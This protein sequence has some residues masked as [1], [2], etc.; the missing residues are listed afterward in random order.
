[1]TLNTSRHLVLSVGH[2]SHLTFFWQ[3][4]KSGFFDTFTISL[5]LQLHKCFDGRQEL[6]LSLSE[7]IAQQTLVL[8]K[9]ECVFYGRNLPK[10]IFKGLKLKNKIKRQ[11]NN[12]DSI[13]L[14]HDNS[15]LTTNLLASCFKN[16]L[17]FKQFNQYDLSNYKKDYFNILLVNT[18]NLFLSKFMNVVRLSSE[19]DSRVHLNNFDGP[20]IKIDS[21]SKERDV[22]NFGKSATK[23]KKNG[24]CIV[25]IPFMTWNISSDS[26]N[27]ILSTYSSVLNSKKFDGKIYY[28]RH[29]NE[30]NA[31]IAAIR[32]VTRDRI[33]D[34]T[35]EFISSEHFFLENPDLSM[36]LSVGSYAAIS[37]YKLG[38]YTKV[39]FRDVPLSEQTL[40]EYEQKFKTLPP[41]IHLSHTGNYEYD[42]AKLNL[43]P[44]HQALSELQ[45]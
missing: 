11:F 19:F 15:S 1:M 6:A 40:A 33:Y 22:L 34:V 8:K 9:S 43:N 25:G 32:D 31:E 37:A 26:K 44:L 35:N 27:I 12:P 7:E 5:I 45:E 18:V 39:F 3:L 24:I 42:N 28:L 30:T 13:L 4:K 41:C 29:P 38:I 2:V 17:L 14:A 23:G 36:V 16:K 20:I 10:H 21:S